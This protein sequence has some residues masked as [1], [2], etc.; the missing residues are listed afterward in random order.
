MSKNNIVDSLH[1][2]F[3]QDTNWKPFAIV[4]GLVVCAT[5]GFYG[6]RWHAA[7]GEQAAQVVFADCMNQ[8]AQAQEG[9]EPWSSVEQFFKMGYEQ[10]SGSKLAPYFLAYQAEALIKQNKLAE[11]VVVMEKALDTMPKSSPVYGMYATKQALMNI[12]SNDAALAQ[13]GLEQL[14]VLAQDTKNL[15]QDVALYN[16]GLYYWSKNDLKKA[17]EVWAGF[18]A[19]QKE[20]KDTSPWAALAEQKLE[21]LA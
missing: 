11:A 18:A 2:D 6:Y 8:L 1:L 19:L 12:D 7:Q 17:Q 3:L 14:Q 13:K 15:G 10:H 4:A 5:A 9:T 21:Y 20:G 16:L